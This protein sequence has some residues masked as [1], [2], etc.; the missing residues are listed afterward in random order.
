MQPGISAQRRALIAEDNPYALAGAAAALADLGF[1]VL[2]AET[3]DH[4]LALIEDGSLHLAVVD[5]ALRRSGQRRADLSSTAGLDV[6]DTMHRTHPQAA[7]VI[8][9]AYP[10]QLPHPAH[11][12]QRFGFRLACVIKGGIAADFTDAVGAAIEGRLWLEVPH[13]PPTM[14]PTEQRFLEA[15]PA[16]LRDLVVIVAQ[17]MQEIELSARERAIIR[18][19]ALLPTVAAER[20]HVKRSTMDE[21]RSDLYAKLGLSDGSQTQHVDRPSIILLGYLLC[22]IRGNTAIHG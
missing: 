14:P 13:Q 4:A 16:E 2:C 7:L 11:L 21:Y 15:L 8:W 12:I 1:E 20:M 17:R 6:L 18:L 9:T 19:I 3:L 22:H 10:H 5:I